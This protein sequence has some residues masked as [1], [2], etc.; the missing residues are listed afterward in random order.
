MS[1][2]LTIPLYHVPE[3]E[4]IRLWEHSERV[5]GGRGQEGAAPESARPD[6]GGLD[7]AIR[8]FAADAGVDGFLLLRGLEIGEIP[9]THTDGRPTTLDAHPT[10]ATLQLVAETLGTMVGYA[11]EKDG[12][13]VHEVQPVPGDETRIENSG[14]VAFD[15]HTENVHH[16]LRPD[17]LGLLCLRQD[18]LGVAAT[19][20]ASV[21]HALALLDDDTVATLRGLWFLSNYPT[22]FT[23]AAGGELPPVG[24]H[25]VIFGDEDRPFLR[26]NS[27]NTFSTTPAG[28]AALVRLTQALE[29]VCHDVVL[30]PGDCVIVDNNVA[31]HGRSGFTPR[32]DGQDRWL[33][34]FY[35]VRAIPR[36]VQHM[37]GGGRVVPSMATIRG[38]W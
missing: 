32:Y 15:F 34:R 8:G 31:A 28:R 24:P 20:V 5:A 21:R 30:E 37:M 36:T 27:H 38:L 19:R 12:R 6:L 33:R 29:E 7:A 11:D 35:S 22:S 14:S 23:R 18:H 16:P 2:A 9:P 13:L 4:R 1:S 10:S 26:F 17:Y 25:P 3:D